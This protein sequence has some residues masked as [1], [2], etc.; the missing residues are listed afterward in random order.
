MDSRT[1]LQKLESL[2]QELPERPKSYGDMNDPD[3]TEEFIDYMECEREVA[4]SVRK[5]LSTRICQLQEAISGVHDRPL[6]I[7]SVGC[8][9]GVT[10]KK[11]LTEVAEKFPQV[12]IQ[13]VGV[14][15]NAAMCSL[16]RKNLSNLP[17]ETTIINANILDIDTKSP[18]ISEQ[19][20]DLVLLA[21]ST[22]YFDK[23]EP[24]FEKLTSITRSGGE[25]Q[26]I[27]AAGSPE[28]R[29]APLFFDREIKFPFRIAAD[30]VGELNKL[31]LKYTELV[32]PGQLN[33]APYVKERFSSRSGRNVLNFICHTK[34]E[35]YPPEVTALCIEYLTDL[36][37]GGQKQIKFDASAA[38]AIRVD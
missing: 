4:E 6:R 24:L 21:H 30:L 25:I 32:L 33:V 12:V 8:G 2:L 26:I 15:T 14:D 11:Y 22:Y 9:H 3:Y 23:L 10:D 18:P 34:L 7:C 28:W 27:V 13:Y 16:A 19:R 36:Y 35:Q 17:Y 29:L 1:V 5:Y 20:F 37:K 31:G 38:I